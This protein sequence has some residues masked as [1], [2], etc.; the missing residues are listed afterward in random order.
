MFDLRTQSTDEPSAVLPYR[1]KARR[2]WLYVSVLTGLFALMQPVSAAFAFTNPT[3]VDLG[4]AANYTVLA[5]TTVTN[6]GLTVVSADAGL[7]GNLGVTPGTAVTGFPPGVVSAPGAI[8]SADT[9]AATAKTA[10]SDAYID[11]A[12]RTPDQTF[13][14]IHDIGGATFT[15]GVYNDPSSFGIT[16]TVTLDGAGNP[17]AV[18]IFQAGS[19][20]ITA[21]S[22][23]VVL[24]NGA[25]AGNVFWQVGSSATLGVNSTFKGTILAQTAITVNTGADV[26]GRVLAGTAAVT[27]DSDAINAPSVAPSSGV[28]QAPLFGSLGWAVTIAAFLAG[29]AMLVLRLRSPARVR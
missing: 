24:V 21:V 16:G 19:T 27:L 20:L 5:A 13:P 26:Q 25:Q 7:G 29:G 17:D 15:A 8:H 12:G 6:T 22:S 18:F 11:A 4:A 14:A 28:P 23:Q 1:P 3:P 2:R 9:S 10:A